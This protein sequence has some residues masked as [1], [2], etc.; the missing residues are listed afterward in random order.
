M[1][2]LDLFVDYKEVVVIECCWWMEEERKLR[3][4][5][6]KCRIIGVRFFFRLFFLNLYIRSYIFL[7]YFLNVLL[8]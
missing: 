8:F 2:K 3:I 4:F 1:Y 6:V 7:F 5:N